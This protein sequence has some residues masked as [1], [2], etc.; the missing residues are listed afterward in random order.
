MLVVRHPQQSGPATAAPIVGGLW[1]A[2]ECAP[3]ELP[4]WAVARVVPAQ[5]SSSA[6]LSISRERFSTAHA[7]QVEAWRRNSAEYEQLLGRLGLQCA[8]IGPAAKRAA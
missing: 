2:Y 5:G 1:A 4:V 6:Y 3:G 7:A 8:T